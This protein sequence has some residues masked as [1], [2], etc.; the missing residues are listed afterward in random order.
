[1]VTAYR[2]VDHLIPDE[3]FQKVI[4]DH[5]QDHRKLYMYILQT[6]Q[7]TKIG[8]LSLLLSTI[9]KSYMGQQILPSTTTCDRPNFSH[10]IHF[11]TYWKVWWQWAEGPLTLR[12][13]KEY[14][15]GQNYGQ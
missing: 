14:K 4:R 13:E 7:A 5:L 2:L 15:I 12:A 6:R 8:L 11:L 10:Y 3:I 9:R 1:M